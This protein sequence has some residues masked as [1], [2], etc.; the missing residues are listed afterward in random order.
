[1]NPVLASGLL[2]LGSDIVRRTL[3]AFPDPTPSVGKS[4]Q[5]DL[6][7]LQEQKLA[8]P[9][10]NQLKDEILDIP[11]VKRFISQNQ[12]CTI[13]MDQLSDGSVR[14][15]SSSGDLM[16]IRSD[17]PTSGILNQYLKGS[18]ATG[19]NLSPERSDSVIL[20]G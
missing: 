4:F 8:A 15:L 16:T 1:M 18:I 14:F 20:T 12:D 10:L 19:Q 6:A 3:P 11:E 7:N 9:D 17:S 13:T 5:A 2:N